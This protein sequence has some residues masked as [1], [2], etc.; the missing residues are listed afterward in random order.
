[1]SRAT[2]SVR[3]FSIY[4]VILGAALVAAPD[5]VLAPFGI[6]HSPEVWIRVVGVLAAVLGLYYFV[7]ARFENVPFYRATVLGRAFVFVCFAAF[8]LL[9]LAPPALALFGTVDLA[10]A[11]WTALGLR[12][13]ASA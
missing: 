3:V 9:G 6:P 1:M 4:L 11:V 12:T 7:A 10:G 2:T 8:V 13:P 5:L